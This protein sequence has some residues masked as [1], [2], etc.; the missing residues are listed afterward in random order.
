MRTLLVCA[1]VATL[2]GGFLNDALATEAVAPAA[3]A[4]PVP[5]ANDALLQKCSP[6]I[7][8]LR[9]AAH[10]AESTAAKAS[11]LP[12]AGGLAKEALA[13]AKLQST[14]ADSLGNDLTNLRAGKAAATDGLLSQIASGKASITDRL[15]SLPGADVLQQVLG[16]PGVASALLQQL[17]VDKV[18]GYATVQAALSGLQ[19]K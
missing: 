19:A 16:S 3:A 12:F 17:P 1:V 8:K 10:A 6:L 5:A 2:C 14:D 15:K 13:K 9:A 18:P 11:A 7:D 4:K